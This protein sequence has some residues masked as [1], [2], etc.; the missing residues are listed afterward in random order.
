MIKSQLDEVI[1]RNKKEFEF[2]KNFNLP[3][4]ILDNNDIFFSNEKIRTPTYVTDQK[5]KAR[6]IVLTEKLLK[7]DFLIKLFV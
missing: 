4:I 5:V 6:I 7:K 3:N 2:H 1:K